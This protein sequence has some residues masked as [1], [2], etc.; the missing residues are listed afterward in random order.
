MYYRVMLKL[1]LRMFLII[2]FYE[3][4][5]EERFYVFRKFF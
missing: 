1:N 2:Y 3:V 4:N 5:R